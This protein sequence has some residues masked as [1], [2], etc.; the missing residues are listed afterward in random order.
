MSR[1]KIG[2][3]LESLGLPLRR[4]LQ[5]A[6]RLGIGGVQVDAAGDLSPNALSQTGR[7]EFRHLLRT[8]NL[9]LSA[10][11]CPLRRGLDSAEN[12]EGRIEHVRKVMTLSYDLGARRVVVQAGRVPDNADEPRAKL[13]TEALRALGQHG[14]RTGTILA[15]ET[16]LES[17]EKLRQ[18]LDGFDSGGLGA[19]YDPANLLINGFDPYQSARDLR[20]R[21]VHAH[22]RDAR[23]A[24][25]S[26]TAQEVPL[27]HGDL[28]WLTLAGVFEEIE[29]RGWLAVERETGENRLADVTAGVAFLRCIIGS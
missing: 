4:A 17:G 25:A 9:E 11:N 2:I 26:R 1:I 20:E 12:Q 29:Y 7:R 27:G 28:D 22:A 6:E 16:G 10:L 24:T 8:H 5:E 3:C 14:D 21:I 19:N 23:L 13:L 15:L 18:F